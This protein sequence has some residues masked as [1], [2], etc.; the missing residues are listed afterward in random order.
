[1]LGE[2][3]I[4]GS[5]GIFSPIVGQGIYNRRKEASERLQGLEA[6]LQELDEE[7]SF[8]LDTGRKFLDGESSSLFSSKTLE[9]DI[10]MDVDFSQ[11]DS[12]EDVLE[13]ESDLVDIGQS[14]LSSM[15]DEYTPFDS[16]IDRYNIT[17]HGDGGSLNYSVADTDFSEGFNGEDRELSSAGDVYQETLDEENIEDYWSLA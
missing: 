17:F 2:A 16:K 4:L 10:D 13:D 9:A 7:S 11:Y 5:A 1:V 15:V 12:A 3:L 8:R 14:T 6:D